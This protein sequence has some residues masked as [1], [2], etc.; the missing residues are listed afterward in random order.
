MANAKTK[1]TQKIKDPRARALFGKKVLYIGDFTCPE[2][3]HKAK[4]TMVSLYKDTY[5]CSENCVL[6]VANV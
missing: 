4:K 2:C 3:G 5:Y 6:K 1:H